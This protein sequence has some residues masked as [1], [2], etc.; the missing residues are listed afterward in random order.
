MGSPWWPGETCWGQN[1][2]CVGGTE[3]WQHLAELVGSEFSL[4]EL[5]DQLPQ[6]DFN[7]MG[8]KALLIKVIIIKILATLYP[9]VTK[10]LMLAREKSN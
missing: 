6:T 3:Y 1:L 8:I 2:V 4:E 10:Y 5:R 7:Q 9:K